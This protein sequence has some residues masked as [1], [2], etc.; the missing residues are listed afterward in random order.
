MDF[1]YGTAHNS[2]DALPITPEHRT[3]L[4][5]FLDHEGCIVPYSLIAAVRNP[6]LTSLPKGIYKPQGWDY[7]LSIK[8]T[9]K[10]P[11]GDIP[12]VTLANGDWAYR[13]HRE[14][15]D[16]KYTN[17][18]LQNCMR[19]G[20][21]VGVLIQVEG[22]PNVRYFVAGLGRIVAYVDP[23]FDLIKWRSL[24]TE[25]PLSRMAAED[26]AQYDAPQQQGQLPGFI[27]DL[28]EERYSQQLVRPNQSMFRVMLLSSYD[29]TCAIT[30]S[31]VVQTLEAAHIRPYAY[32]KI[33]TIHNGLLL[34]ADVHRLFDT[35][36]IG[37]NTN[38]MEAIVS[39]KLIGT[40][41]EQYAGE[42]LNLPEDNQ[43]R[44]SVTLLDEHRKTW[45]LS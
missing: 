35:G 17:I 10:S 6:H 3:R 13:Y 31:K 37:V 43:V 21:P 38:H 32:Q 9:L 40:E 15:G 30:S 34:R 11:Y 18:G 22:K 36:L 4:Q 5:W 24:Q 20:I 29:K 27:E 25:I 45:H 44:P 2:L 41:Y 14:D 8:E 19:D 1:T 33:D 16:G 28:L 39:S 42:P 26:V 23:W 7:S 12:I